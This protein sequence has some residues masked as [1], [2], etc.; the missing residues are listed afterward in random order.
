MDKT[1]TKEEL[2]LPSAMRERWQ[3]IRGGLINLYRFDEQEFRYQDGR[4]LL[5]GNN[6]TGKSR[7]LALQ[8]PF[9]L[10]GEIA[11]QR[12]EP[13]GDPAKRMEWNLL[14]GGKYDDRLGYTWIEFG[15]V[16]EHGQAEYK[17]LG[18]A[19]RAVQGRGIV[20]QWL[21]ITSQRIGCDLFLEN[22]LGQP[23]SRAKLEAA[24]GDAGKVYGSGK[25]EEDRREYR[26]G[27]DSALFKL[28]DRYDALVNLLIQLRQP[29][30]SRTLNEQR[31]SDALS[32]ALPPLPDSVLGDVAEAFRSLEADRQEL[33]DFVAARDSAELFLKEYRR[34]IQIAARRRAEEV[35]KAQSAYE[36]TMRQLRAAQVALD[37]AQSELTQLEKRIAQLEIDEQHALAEEKTLRD[38]PEMKDARTL[39]EARLAA[40]SAKADAAKAEGEANDAAARLAREEQQQQLAVERADKAW[41]ETQKIATEALEAAQPIGLETR[42]RETFERLRLPDVDASRVEQIAAALRDALKRRHDAARHMEQLNRRVDAARQQLAIAQEAFASAEADLNESFESERRAL[43]R[44][45]DKR[46]ALFVAYRT[47]AGGV[48]ETRPPDADEIE[49]RFDDWCEAAEG[50]SPLARAVKESEHQASQ[51]IAASRAETAARLETAFAQERELIGQLRTLQSG[52]HQPPPVPHTRD[53]AAR[54]N[55]AGAPLWALCDF[56]PTT[57]ESDRANIEAALESSGLLD[58]WVTPDGRLLDV[59][60]HDTLLVAGASVPAPDGRNLAIVLTPSIDRQHPQGRAVSESTV[61]TLLAQIGFGA[62]S[63]QVWVDPSGRWQVG[64][65][66]GTW[67]KEVSQ[68][69]G[70]AAREAA[71]RRRIAELEIDLEAAARFIAGIQ[72]ELAELDRRS[73][74]LQREIASAPVDAGVRHALIQIATARET[75][76]GRRL[77]LTEAENRLTEKRRL[78]TAAVAERDEAARDLG[79]ID[80]INNLGGLVEAIH[81]YGQILAGLWP[82]IRAHAAAREQLACAEERMME[83]AR[84]RE[85]RVASLHELE[86]MAAVAAAKFKVLESTIGATVREVRQKLEDALLRVQGVR[87]E[88]KVAEEERGQRRIDSAVSHKDIERANVDLDMRNAEREVVIGLLSSFV[89]TRQLGVA[90]SDFMEV[91]SGAWSVARAVDLARRIEAALRDVDHGDGAWSRNQREIH[92]HF[93]TLQTSLRAHGQMPEAS[94]NDGLFIVTIQFHGRPCTI[95]DL[96][97]T[98]VVIL[99]ER[100]ELLDA[101]EREVLENYLIDEVAEHLH[102]LLH[103]AL[104]WR[105]EINKELRERPMSTGMTLRFVWDPFEDLSPA[106]AEARRLL[107]SARDTWSPAERSAVGEFLQQQIK[108]VRVANEMGTWQDHLAEAFDYRKWHHFGIERKQD[109][110]WK[111]LTR[112]THGTGSGGEKAVALTLPQLAAAA[113]HYRSADVNAPRLILLDEAFV[114]VDK[115][116]RAKCMDLLQAFDLDVVMTSESEWACY[117]TI[118]AIAIYQ[119]AAREGIDAVHATRWVWNGRQRVRDDSPIPSARPPET[120]DAASPNSLV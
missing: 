20:Q 31:L 17:T 94:M 41:A 56:L 87:A 115:N 36:T 77:R 90:H 26:R 100:Q 76:S 80:W 49:S 23:V 97:D 29:Q 35:R 22:E 82:A 52:F 8:L 67:R 71:R 101:R 42:H 34:Y 63:G 73:A 75:V 118:P 10:D 91:D 5:R 54:G 98:V 110:V 11:P 109:G 81:H 53:D 61:A 30:L 89:N 60:E 96:R 86:G 50:E 55:R 19:L 7:V 107:L 24:I 43:A 25:I 12:V 38:S 102:D 1:E 62:D 68:H 114:G 6:G 104:R 64:P 14:L 74:Q 3:P 28:G 2:I 13:D 39:E 47:W 78:A 46:D 113:A 9:L 51:R 72:E 105:E 108:S 117:P 111:R 16:N 95:A 79:L 119:L 88:K 106:F 83:A 18:C 15:R 32:Q 37:L 65:L 48:I 120:Q 45:E 93:E 21:F 84:H 57:P 70:H 58:A 4:L 40:E 44:L 92:G 85:L 59:H 116:M 112:R 99:Q 66:H 27:I 69:I 103:H 33:N